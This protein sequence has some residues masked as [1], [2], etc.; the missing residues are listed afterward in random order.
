MSIC[1]VYPGFVANKRIEVRVHG[2]LAMTP[3][4][5][6]A[7]QELVEAVAK[8][9]QLDLGVHVVDPDVEHKP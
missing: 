8:V 4:T 6:V 7:I 1:R 2:L 5:Q 9:K 3:A